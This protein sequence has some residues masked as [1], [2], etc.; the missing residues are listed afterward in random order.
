MPRLRWQRKNL[1]FAVK[2]LRSLVYKC[3]NFARLFSKMIW[4]QHTKETYYS[5]CSI[6]QHASVISLTFYFLPA[7]DNVSWKREKEGAMFQFNAKGKQQKRKPSNVPTKNRA[8]PSPHLGFLFPKNFVSSCYCCLYPPKLTACYIFLDIK[9]F[10]E[11][12]TKVPQWKCKSLSKPLRRCL[13][14]M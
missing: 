6:Y 4:S 5:Q 8:S 7:F 13:C 10:G 11:K 3:P 2:C 14:R 12:L 1:R 9:H